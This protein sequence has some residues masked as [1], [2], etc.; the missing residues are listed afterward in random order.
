[1]RLVLSLLL[2]AIATSAAGQTGLRGEAPQFTCTAEM[3]GCL[4]TCTERYNTCVGSRDGYI[5]RPAIDR[6]LA[7]CRAR[8]CAAGPLP[9]R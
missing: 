9:P 1:M 3:N 2:A 7:A 8:F 4:A 6:C 5:C